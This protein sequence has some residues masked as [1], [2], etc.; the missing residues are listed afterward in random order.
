MSVVVRPLARG[1]RRRGRDVLTDAFTDDPVWRAIGPDRR[2]H[3]RLVQR[4]WFTSALWCAA[5]WGNPTRAAV[6]DGRVDGVA[7]CF[8]AEGYPPPTV[9]QTLANAPFLLGGP[10]PIARAMKV[11]EAM[12][13]NHM[14]EPHLYL[15]LLA[16]HPD[17]Q[18]RGVGR[19]LLADIAAEADRR[20]L[21]VYL[22]TFTPDNVPY[23]ASF[24]FAIDE[25]HEDVVRG[26]TL[27][28]M[29][30]PTA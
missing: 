18:R 3:R 6:R 23:Y 24:G 26:A 20:E 22:E 17:A 29:T 4:G 9:A 14:R 19:A 21:P 13:A 30:R 28:R 11:D 16:A 25:V 12:A 8:D 27:W 15:W 2:A 1:E 5:R 10:L 7:V